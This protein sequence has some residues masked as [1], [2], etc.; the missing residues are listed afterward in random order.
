MKNIHNDCKGV[1]PG[2][3][4]G[5]MKQNGPARTY[6]T[7]EAGRVVSD[8][9]GGGD[10]TLLLTPQ[11]SVFVQ[12]YAESRNHFAAYRAA[13]PIDVG[14]SNSTAY[15]RACEVLRR[16]HI[17]AAVGVLRD[18]MN[19]DTLVRATDMLRDLVDIASANPNELVSVEKYNCRQCHGIDH[20]PQWIDAGELARALDKWL[21]AKK[22][23]GPMPS[24]AGGFGFEIKG[25]PAPDCPTCLGD[26]I[27]RRI[28]RDT[29]KLSPQARKLLKSVD[30]AADGSV[31][32]VMHD[33]M[34]ARDMIIKML[35]AYKDPK[36]A[37]PP[38]PGGSLE[39]IDK[40]ATPEDAQ[41]AYLTLI[42]N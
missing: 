41:R 39:P 3:T 18:Q 26:G 23:S 9:P 13:Y 17:I 22:K 2:A 14:A 10:A 11:E 5:D 8:V 4:V 7:P 42:K 38:T 6:P 15:R 30:V 33:Q 27:E 1:F 37:A 35:G 31:R 16:P 20:A 36:Q 34:Q 25:E 19:A 32:I 21:N 29:T 28:V 12:V 24:A 40:D